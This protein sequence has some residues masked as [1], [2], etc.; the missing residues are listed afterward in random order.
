[1]AG[2][3][4]TGNFPKALEGGGGSKMAKKKVGVKKPK[5]GVKKP[6]LKMPSPKKSAGKG[7]GGGKKKKPAIG[8]GMSAL[9][10]GMPGPMEPPK[11]G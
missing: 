9:M 1:M 11:L 8:A 7:G 2:V 6:S 10:G 5:V 4:T 3:I